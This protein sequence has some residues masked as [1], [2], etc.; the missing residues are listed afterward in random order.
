M[1]ERVSES[2]SSGGEQTETSDGE[3]KVRAV[4]VTPPV[5]AADINTTTPTDATTTT[6]DDITATADVTASTA[7]AIADITDV[8][9]SKSQQSVCTP[10]DNVDV[11]HS[12]QPVSTSAE[13]KAD[14]DSTAAASPSS[15]KPVPNDVTTT[16]RSENVTSADSSAAAV[17]VKKV[18]G[19]FDVDSLLSSTT[20]EATGPHGDVIVNASVEA[21]SNMETKASQPISEKQDTTDDKPLVTVDKPAA[22]DDGSVVNDDTPMNSDI[23]SVVKED[24]S[25]ASDDAPIVNNDKLVPVSKVDSPPPA[26]VKASDKLVIVTGTETKQEDIKQSSPHVSPADGTKVEQ[27]SVTPTLDVPAK[28]L[29]EEASVVESNTPSLTT[30]QPVTET[31][32]SHNASEDKTA[33]VVES[34]S[35]PVIGDH[36]PLPLSV[37]V[38]STPV[39]DETKTLP[40]ATEEKA[41]PVITENK[42]VGDNNIVPV[43]EENK[44]LPDTATLAPQSKTKPAKK[45]RGAVK[46][47]KPATSRTPAKSRAKKGAVKPPTVEAT[48]SLSDSEDEKPLIERAA[49]KKVAAGRRKTPARG[50]AVSAAAEVTSK[51]CNDAAAD[52]VA[53]S[54]AMETDSSVKVKSDKPK[55]EDSGDDNKHNIRKTVAKVDGAIASGGDS[56]AGSDGE[57]RGG[58]TERTLRTGKQLTAVE[59]LKEEEER[60]DSSATEEY[61]NTADDT[62]AATP[63]VPAAAGG[64]KRKRT[65]GARGTAKTSKSTWLHNA[66]YSCMICHST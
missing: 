29:T 58:R 22:I 63:S 33:P 32:A 19:P 30:K 34:N 46:A 37:K 42:V 50:K 53:S 31:K 60:K 40:T 48:A 56:D 45:A 3:G 7:D 9:A 47:T 18:G 4:T 12:P 21:R 36:K 44:P 1:C 10:P 28:E 26:D 57:V 39:I 43:I 64:T 51:P 23:K 59:R 11:Q 13:S 66:M 2:S 27:T 20:V 61:D 14:V 17:K 24:R 52:N 49:S 6:S 25:V 65:K 55:D 35:L 5:A 8:P 15:V 62:P 54:E 38:E 41:L 16:Q